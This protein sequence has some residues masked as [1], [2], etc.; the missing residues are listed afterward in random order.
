MAIVN[1]IKSNGSDIYDLEKHR[2]NISLRAD[3]ETANISTEGL[4]ISANK[5]DINGENASLNSS[6]SNNISGSNTAIDISKE[7]EIGDMYMHIF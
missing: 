3:N 5:L 1:I 4:N 7:G 2:A 6:Q